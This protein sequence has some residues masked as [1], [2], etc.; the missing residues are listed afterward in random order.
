MRFYE[1]LNF[2][3]VVGSMIIPLIFI[4]LFAVGISFMPLINSKDKQSEKKVIQVFNDDIQKAEGPFPLIMALIIAGT[5]IW[6]VFYIF[7]YGFSEAM[8]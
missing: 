3:H 1:L 4:I 8:L 5:V 6:G 7:Y 2:Q